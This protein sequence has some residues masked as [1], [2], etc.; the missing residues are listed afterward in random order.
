MTETPFT[1]STAANSG[2]NAVNYNDPYYISNGDTSVQNLGIQL[3]NGDNFVGWNRGVCLALGAT[4]KLGFIDGTITKPDPTSTDFQKWIRNDYMITCWILRSMEKSLAESFASLTSIEQDDLSIAEYYGKM[5]KVWDELQVFD[6]IPSCSCGAMLRCTCNLLKKILEADQLKKLIQFL[7]GLHK[8]YEQVKVNILS[9][10]PLPTVL[11][12]YHI[13]QQV[14]KQ[15]R[16]STHSIEISALMAGKH[17]QSYKFQPSGQG[18]QRKD[19]KKTKYD[20]Y[21]KFDR[22]CDHCKVKGHMKDQCFKLVGYPEWYT[23][24]KGKSVQKFAANI[25]STGILGSSPLDFDPE[26]QAGSSSVGTSNVSQ[27]MIEAVFKGVMKMMPS[28]NQQDNNYAALNFAGI[29]SVSNAASFC[30][31]FD[32]NS[33][34]IDTGASD[35]MASN[36]ALFNTLQN[37]KQPLKVGLPDGSVKYITQI[38]TIQLTPHIVLSNVLYIPDFKHNLLSVGR[39]LD[40][41]KLYAHFSPTSCSFQD[42]ITNEVKAVGRRQAGLYKFSEDSLKFN[43]ASISNSVASANPQTSVHISDVISLL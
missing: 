7:A 3:F 11:R 39:L 41:N 35:H 28:S 15:N 40:H 13:L 19:F 23:N 10:D 29:T 5:K 12:A 14:E 26:E 34:I 27:E 20:K 18:V 1:D 30:K 9:M 43:P 16:N 38:G 6:E 17:N 24:L 25:D 33:R 2:N 4:N 21:D 36:L 22:F 8:D 37:L 32:E 31:I 42:L